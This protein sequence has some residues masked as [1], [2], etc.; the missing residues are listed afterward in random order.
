MV[1]KA[2]V[3][4]TIKL[5]PEIKKIIKEATRQLDSVANYLKKAIEK[6]ITQ[7]TSSK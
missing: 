2:N 1:K 6:G 3:T 5:D 4:I 7:S